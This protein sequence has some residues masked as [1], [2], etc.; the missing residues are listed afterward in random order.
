MSCKDCLNNNT[1]E[2][3]T[4]IENYR[5]EGCKDFRRVCYLP[6]KIGDTVWAIRQRNGIKQICEGKVS[7]M[8]FVGEEMR[9]CIVVK[10]WVRGTWGRD[11]FP[12][13]EEAE[14]MLSE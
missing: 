13:R 1:C 9:L 11:V 2:K 14:R 6:C 5:L 3:A 10:S 8:C 12:S 4:H 7:E